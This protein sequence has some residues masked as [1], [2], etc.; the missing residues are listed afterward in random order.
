MALSVVDSW[1]HRSDGRVCLIV[2]AGHQAD[3]ALD[4][5]YV[6]GDELDLRV[7]VLGVAQGAGVLRFPKEIMLQTIEENVKE[8]FVEKN[9]E[10]FLYGVSVGENLKETLAAGGDTIPARELTKE[11]REQ[12][13]NLGEQIKQNRAKNTLR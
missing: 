5:L 8:A 6:Q 9:K 13:A 12:L 10:A 11:E 3:A 1:C 7:A 4:G 2:A